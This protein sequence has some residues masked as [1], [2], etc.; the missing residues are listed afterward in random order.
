MKV[1]DVM[2]RDV[3]VA[4]PEQSLQQAARLMCELDIGA[5][6]V[7]DNERLVGMITDRDIVIRAVADGLGPQAKVEDAMTSDVKYCYCDQELAEVSDNM[8]DIQLRRLPVLN[9]DKRLVGI[10]ALGDIATSS[11]NDCAADA[12]AGISRPR[13]DGRA[14]PAV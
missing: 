6:P 7:A 10:L 5:L 3:A 13:L 14:Q 8:A 2:T 9:R 4:S 12:L 11:D 1:E